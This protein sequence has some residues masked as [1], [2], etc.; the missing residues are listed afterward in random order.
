MLTQE[1]LVRFRGAVS[2]Y[3]DTP[4]SLIQV[5]HEAQGIF[6][7]LSY[8]V[9]KTIAEEMNMPLADIYG[10][11]TFYSR[12]N[13]EPKGLYQINVCMGTACYV[14]GAQMI[15]DKIIDMLGVGVGHTTADGYFSLEAGR[16]FGCCGLAPVM[17]VNEAVFG[18]LTVPGAEKI[19]RDYMKKAA[20]GE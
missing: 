17:T 11:A 2:A 10:V 6:G 15:L 1:S 20:G 7:C 3:K 14:R 12:F 19:I 16:C 4:G 9:E 5:M 18:S 13:L 8:E